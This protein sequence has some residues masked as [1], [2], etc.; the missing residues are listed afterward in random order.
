MGLRQ[1]R[2]GGNPS[3]GPDHEQADDGLEVEAGGRKM[4][5]KVKAADLRP[6]GD[7]APDQALPDEPEVEKE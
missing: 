1:T 7:K 6:L 2:T 5:V 3:I 4:K